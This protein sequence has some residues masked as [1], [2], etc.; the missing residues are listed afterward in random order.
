MVALKPPNVRKWQAGGKDQGRL[1]GAP[2]RAAMPIT[3]LFS[4]LDKLEKK[5]VKK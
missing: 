4:I 1:A 5:E 3:E 2:S